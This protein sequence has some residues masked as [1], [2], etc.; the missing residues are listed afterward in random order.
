V[1]HG[2]AQ[3]SRPDSG[4][5][6]PHWYE[7][8]RKYLLTPASDLLTREQSNDPRY[9]TGRRIDIHPFAQGLLPS[10]ER[11]FFVIEGKLKNDAIL[12]YIIEH[13][14]RASVVNVPSVWQW[15]AAEL[16]AF[17]SRHL[18]GKHVVI[19][20][21]SD[22]FANDQVDTPAMLFRSRLWKL[23]VRTHIAAPPYEPPPAG[24][25]KPALNGIDDFLAAGGD[26]GSMVVRDVDLP[27]A[28]AGAS[29]PRSPVG[30]AEPQPSASPAP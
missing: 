19:V 1:P 15:D 5:D 24:E 17:A 29:A 16:D 20:P 8:K 22:W 26:L 21:D 27:P 13:G 9:N 25:N 18:R 2:C 11:V 14:L 28:D 10:A 3:N 6:E 7:R 12:T 30:F 4:H 23:G